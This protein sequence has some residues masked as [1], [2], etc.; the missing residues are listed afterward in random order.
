MTKRRP[1]QRGSIPGQFGWRLIEM[2]E[3][4]ANRTLSLGAKRV[5]E[6]LEIELGHHGNKPEENG[7][8]ACTYE[9]FV[10][11]GLHRHAIGPAIRELVALGFVEITRKGCAGNA[12]FRQPTLYRLTYRFAGSDKHVT[13]EWRRITTREEAEAIARRARAQSSS[14]EDAPKTKVQCRKPSPKPV[15][16][17]VTETAQFPVPETVTT[18]PVPETTTTSISRRGP[19]HLTAGRP[20]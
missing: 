13:D 5:M 9:H 15:P 14:S 3:C 8:L 2:L 1:K 18:V 12:G 11:F 7:K 17:T 10:E 20:A 4:P 19:S 6:R 16:E